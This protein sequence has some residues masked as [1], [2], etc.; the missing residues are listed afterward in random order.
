MITFP[1]SHGFLACFWH[2]LNPCRSTG[3]I[4]SSRYVFLTWQTTMLKLSVYLT[5]VTF[6]ACLGVVAERFMSPS[7]NEHYLFG[8]ALPPSP[9]EMNLIADWLTL[10]QWQYKSMEQPAGLQFLSSPWLFYFPLSTRESFRNYLLWSTRLHVI[11]EQAVTESWGL[12]LSGCS[13]AFFSSGMKFVQN[14]ACFLPCISCLI[15]SLQG[16]GRR[17]DSRCEFW[18]P[19]THFWWDVHSLAS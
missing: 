14:C 16:C 1:A 19:Q 9:F 7:E 12:W 17:M 15:S 10:S 13:G 18:F 8:F 2:S 11:Q 4:L 3:Y 6:I 5:Y